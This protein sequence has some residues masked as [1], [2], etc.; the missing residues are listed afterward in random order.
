MVFLVV[1]I[2]LFFHLRKGRDASGQSSAPVADSHLFG[3]LFSNA[4]SASGW[5]KTVIRLTQV[6]FALMVLSGFGPL[7]FRGGHLSGYPLVLHLKIALLFVI[8]LAVVALG[9]P[10]TTTSEE[11]SGVG[12]ATYWPADALQGRNARA[13]ENGCFG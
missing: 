9:S 6:A 13:P 12:C 7:L 11:G 1:L 2:G 5:R 8:L 3:G 10:T 4:L